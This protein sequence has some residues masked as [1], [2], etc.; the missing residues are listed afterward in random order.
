M[1]LILYGSITSFLIGTCKRNKNSI[2]CSVLPDWDL[3]KNRVKP[4]NLTEVY[5][6]AKAGNITA[7]A[8][9][10][11]EYLVIVWGNFCQVCM[12]T[13]VVTPHLNRLDETVQMMG[14]NIWY[15]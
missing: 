15:N 8:L 4:E 1:G 5:A 9:D 3:L 7:R 10:K 2:K 11:R 6:S 13:Y 12:K 14:H